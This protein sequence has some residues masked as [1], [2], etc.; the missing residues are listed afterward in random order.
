LTRTLLLIA[1]GNT[2]RRD[3]NAGHELA[4]RLEPLLRAACIP[5]QRLDMHQLLPETAEEVAQAGMVVFL[6][7]STTEK[8]VGWRIVEPG[9]EP[10]PLL[11]AITPAGVLALATSL[12]NA[13]PPAYL[14]TVPGFDFSHGEELS[15]E[16]LVL[17]EEAARMWPM[18]VKEYQHIFGV[19]DE[20]KKPH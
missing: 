3:D 9:V 4:A 2:L 16:T 14:L 20:G 8:I 6:D 19:R 18:L 1:I 10:A 7:A 5:L 12:F 11:H 17:V 13:S 15:R